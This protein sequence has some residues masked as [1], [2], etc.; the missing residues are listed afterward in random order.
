MDDAGLPASPQPSQDET[1]IRFDGQGRLA[2]PGANPA[3]CRIQLDADR[4]EIALAD[5]GPILA[6][7]RDIA[8]LLPGL[9]SLLL[10]LGGGDAGV[11]IVL[12]QL[13]TQLATLIGLLRERRTRQRLN[14]ALVQLEPD[15]LPLLEYRLGSEHAVAQLA[16]H[17]WGVVLVPL[18]DT[19]ATRRIRRAEIGSVGLDQ[20]SG[21]VRLT[22][23]QGDPAAPG[24]GGGPTPLELPGLG[25][26]ATAW[27]Q[28]LSEL[29]DG[30]IRDAATLVGGLVP[31]APFG[32]RQLL[33][34]LLVDGRPASTSELGAELERVDGAVLTEPVFAASFRELLARGDGPVRWFAMAPERPGADARRAWYL[35][36]LPGNLIALELV[37]EGAHAT[38]LFRVVP[39]AAYAGEGP[40]AIAGDHGSAAREISEA[41]LDARFLR[42][43]I[44]LPAAQLANAR[45]LRYRL[46]LAALPSLAAARR[47]FVA[48]LVHDDPA[49]WAAALDAL[50][51]WH[52]AARDEATE[53]PGRATEEAAVGAA[54]DEE[55]KNNAGL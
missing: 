49:R 8:S 38:Y 50:I 34:R 16:V 51:A 45:N 26:G 4:F 35:V 25:S 5:E 14:D 39:R 41:L 29:R 28:R 30:A 48:R 27:S 36:A 6:D 23:T 7:Y 19:M 55:T 18:D 42:E 32:S 24:E 3:R 44:A 21:T 33:G 22:L 52:G 13:G 43:P 15:P 2:R 47:R 1:S 40:M 37:S 46:A 53:W 17:P 11:R 54:G 10:A 31:D 9:G 20:A 12:E